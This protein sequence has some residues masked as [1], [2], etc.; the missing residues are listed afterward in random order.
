MANVSEIVLS[1]A[2]RGAKAAQRAD[3]Q[4]RDSVKQTGRVAREESGTVSRWMQRHKTAILG[5]AAATTGAMAAIIS[6]SP[7]LSAQLAQVRLGFSLLAMTIGEDVAPIT[8]DA[9]ELMIDLAERY[10]QLDDSVREPISQ[11]VLFGG[12]LGTVIL[13]AALAQK[14]IAGTFIAKGIA[15]VAG[16]LSGAIGSILAFI[17]AK[18]GIIAIAKGVIAAIA[19]IV[20]AIGIV[21][22][23]IA[24]AIAAV[25]AFAAAYI[26]NIGGVRDRTNEILGNVA[27]FFATHLGNARDWAL[28][29]LAALR[30]GAT[31]RLGDARDAVR[32]RIEEAADTVRNAAGDARDWA[33]SRFEDL[34]SGVEDILSGFPSFMMDLG[35]DV[36]DSLRDGI[37]ER[38]MSVVDTLGDMGD[39]AAER[40]AE[41]FN[42]VIPSSISIPSRSIDVPDSLGGGSV[43][44][45]GGSLDIP[46]LAEGGVVDRPTLAMI[47]EAGPEAVVPLD[48][49]D[50]FGGS[51]GGD[52]FVSI[53]FSERSIMIESSGDMEMDIRTM[54]REIKRELR[55]EFGAGGGIA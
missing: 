48:R 38:V 36:I 34:R 26:F 6:A 52:T 21:P 14:I 28:E 39:M 12:V 32:D 43:T 31:E 41:A 37:K 19:G 35:R 40:F 16:A 23:I 33:I 44:I 11:L 29:R 17:A 55:R 25:V 46:Q 42:E 9:S 7:T 8:E 24:A 15:L 2:A 47:G 22:I 13:L 18:G 5:I 50:E 1:Y 45:G 20:A 49:S 30:D 4:V 27:D 51:S 54:M 3:N 53:E 10:E